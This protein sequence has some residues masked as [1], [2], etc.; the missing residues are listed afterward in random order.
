[1]SR[2]VLLNRDIVFV[3]NHRFSSCYASGNVTLCVLESLDR[4]RRMSRVTAELLVSD[5]T[6]MEQLEVICVPKRSDVLGS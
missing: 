6:S 4:C 5:P 1:M 2:D 3:S